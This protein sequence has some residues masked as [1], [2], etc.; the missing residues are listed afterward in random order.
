VALLEPDRD[1]IEQFVDAIFRHAKEGFVSVRSFYQE[2]RDRSFSII[3]ASLTPDRRHLFDTAEDYARR[4]AQFPEPITFCPPIAVFWNKDRARQEDLAEGPAISVECD[5]HPR[6][7]QT[8]LEAIL[9]PATCVVRSG[10]IWTNGNGEA[11]DKLHI[12]WRLTQPARTKD[13][14]RKLKEARELAAKIVDGD[15]TCAPINHPLRWPGS[16]HRKDEPRLCVIEELNADVEIDLDAAL[17]ELTAKAPPEPKATKG[18]RTNSTRDGSAWAEL[19]ANI[20]NGKELHNS[21]A[22][23]A[24]TLLRSGMADGAAVNMLRATMEASSAVHDERWQSRYDDIPRAVSTAR[25]K[26]DGEEEAEQDAEQGARTD[27][28]MH[29]HGEVD[30]RESR[31]YLVQDV[32]PETGIGLVSGQWGTFKTFTVF[33]LTHCIMTGM[34]FLGFPIVRRGG[35]LFIALEGTEEVAIRLQGVI[36]HKGRLLERAP[37]AWR[38]TCPSLLDKGAARILCKIAEEAAAAMQAKF[39]LPLAMIVIDTLIAAAGYS[40]EGQEN[41]SAIGNT[42]MSTLKQ[43]ARKAGC[44]VFGVDHFG[45]DASTGTRGTSAKETAADVLLA[46]IGDRSISGEITNTRLA[47]RKRR[48]GE[49]GQEFPFKPRRVDMGVDA[50]GAPMT[51]LIIDWGAADQTPKA[52]ADSGWS[53]SLRLLRQTLMNMIADCGSEQRPYADGPIVRA[54]DIETIRAEFYKAYPA[55]GDAK[56]KQEVRRKAFGRTVKD[57]QARGLIGV[58]EIGGTTFVWLATLAQ[59]T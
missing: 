53:K 29:W 1:Q 22:R 15:P 58:R 24:M 31:P 39:G 30:H 37:F 19:M 32:I 11:E 34:P 41:D 56:A 7:A 33:D 13:E 25:E 23:L 44:F 17:K 48:G 54:V 50:Y 21:I 18:D 45:K 6:Q 43:V 35:V 4:A 47:L 27:S 49:N 2:D 59:S 42:I 55:D 10:G 8:T 20:T 46:L 16:W 57:A 40:K 28:Q 51:T 26:I 3:P 12:H 14:L 9:G 36:D 5:Q 52:A 38:T